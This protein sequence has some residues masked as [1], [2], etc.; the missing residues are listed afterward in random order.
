MLCDIT[1][2]HCD[3]I[4][5]QLEK[6]SGADPGKVPPDGWLLGHGS[7]PV[8]GCAQPLLGSCRAEEQ[9]SAAVSDPARR[10]PGG[11]SALP[12]GRRLRGSAVLEA[13]SVA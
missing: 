13:F 3:P 6:T 2:A 12:G 7:T 10:G 9:K 1:D 11:A 8:P 5:P 4:S